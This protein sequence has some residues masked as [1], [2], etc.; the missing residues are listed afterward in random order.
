MLFVPATISV[1][2]ETKKKVEKLKADFGIESMDELLDEMATEMRNNMFEESSE[3]FRKRLKEKGLTIEDIQEKGR[4][5][6]RE[7]L[8][9]LEL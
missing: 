7:L 9:N 3:E 1:S 8:R 4:E 5:V 6:R 2:E